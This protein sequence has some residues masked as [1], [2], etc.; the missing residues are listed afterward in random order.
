MGGRTEEE[1][2]GRKDEMRREE[3]G[4]RCS[5]LGE[6]WRSSVDMQGKGKQV[7]QGR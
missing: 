4:Y 7:M 6:R 3:G 2:G 5:G 1:A